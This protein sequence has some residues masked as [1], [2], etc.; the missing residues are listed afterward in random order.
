MSERERCPGSGLHTTAEPGG[1]SKCPWCSKKV[2]VTNGGSLR[3]HV[4]KK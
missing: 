2:T 1:K 4:P 3:T